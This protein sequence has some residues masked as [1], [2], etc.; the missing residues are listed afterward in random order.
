MMRASKPSSSR[1]TASTPAAKH[2]PSQTT[3]PDV[4]DS[5]LERNRQLVSKLAKLRQD[6]SKLIEELR[7]Y[8]RRSVVLREKNALLRAETARLSIRES[9]VRLS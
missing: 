1:S 3:D 6:N 8:K 2:R 7:I 5:L 4:A 9:S